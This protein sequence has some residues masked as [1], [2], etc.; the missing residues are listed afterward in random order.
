MHSKPLS[1]RLD[2][3][4]CACVKQVQMFVPPSTTVYS[5]AAGSSYDAFEDCFRAAGSDSQA[6]AAA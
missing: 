3:T 5:L 1:D 2:M 4:V 6:L